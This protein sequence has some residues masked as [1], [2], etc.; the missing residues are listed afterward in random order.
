MTA[1]T[2]ETEARPHVSAGWMTRFGLLYLGQNVAWAGPSALLVANQVAGW[3]PESKETRL[4]VVMALGGVISMVATPLAGAVSDR[5]RSRFG[6]RA[7][8]ILLGALGAAVSLVVL[9]FA[10]DYAVLV[11]GWL[12]FQATIAFTINAA[13][14]VPP[15]TVPRLQY[16]VVSGVMG[17]TYTLAIVVGTAIATAFGGRTAYL[18][19]ALVLLVLVAQFLVAFRDPPVT[20]RRVRDS[21]TAGSGRA[22]LVPS[23]R[24]HPDFAWVFVTRLLVTL[25]NTIALFYLLYF[26]RDRVKVADPDAGVLTLTVVYA[27]AVVI[28]AVVGGRWSDRVDRRRIFVAGSSLGVAVA[29][30]IMAFTLSWSVVVVA[31]LVLG[32]SWG[33]YMAVDQALINEVLPSAS[34][35]G[36]DIGLMNLA[37]VGPNALAPVIAALALNSLGG[38][39]GLY[40]LSGGL[41]LLG[42]VLVFRVRSVR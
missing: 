18:V 36:R 29:A 19:C 21:A 8:W 16:G 12:A 17:L 10:P 39:T 30:G 41:S 26:L 13:Q 23:P 3:Y 35:R 20:E 32:A 6:R 7:P 4:A 2:H 42:A 33:V 40:L 24:E 38:Y 5:T 27:V 11:A 25:G 34:D 14:A 22:A 9:G 31:A 28:T 1:T 15:D 37:V